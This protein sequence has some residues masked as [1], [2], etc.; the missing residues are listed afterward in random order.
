MGYGLGWFYQRC[1]YPENQMHIMEQK[2]K[3]SKSFL[4]G[5]EGHTYET[6]AQTIVRRADPNRHEAISA[7]SLF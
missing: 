4:I 7:V 6:S 3:N 5:A 1:D 2:F